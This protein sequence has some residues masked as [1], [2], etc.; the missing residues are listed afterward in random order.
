MAIFY[1]AVLFYAIFLAWRYSPIVKQR[2]NIIYQQ[3]FNITLF[4]KENST[5]LFYSTVF[6][7]IGKY[8]IKNSRPIEGLYAGKS[9]VTGYITLFIGLSILFYLIFKTYKKTDL[10]YGTIA[11]VLYIFIV[12]LQ[13]FLGWIMILV[14]IL[15]AVL[16]RGRYDDDY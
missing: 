13:Y 16:L 6:I 14:L 2:A 4:S 5:K 1:L 7:F 3:K 15:L 9:P 10:Y 12:A 8:N 11:A